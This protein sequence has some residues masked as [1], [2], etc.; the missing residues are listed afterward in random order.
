MT[1]DVERHDVCER[2]DEERPPFADAFT[3]V[4]RFILTALDGKAADAHVLV[5][6][7]LNGE[8]PNELLRI[9]RSWVQEEQHGNKITVIDTEEREHLMR[10]VPTSPAMPSTNLER[11]VA[12]PT[13]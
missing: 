11:G 10:D 6:T 4:H 7:F 9:S 2:Q 1:S 8:L 3:L 12:L 5:Q 13:S